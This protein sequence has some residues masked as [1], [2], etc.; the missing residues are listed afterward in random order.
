MELRFP[1]LLDDVEL[2]LANGREHLKMLDQ[3]PSVLE[4]RVVGSLLKR[5][6]S[7]CISL[8]EIEDMEV[9]N[10][11]LVPLRAVLKIEREESFEKLD[12]LLLNQRNEVVHL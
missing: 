9:M 11:P 8:F 1:S 6:F 4:A 12:L 7:F 2:E 5:H 10:L 3:V